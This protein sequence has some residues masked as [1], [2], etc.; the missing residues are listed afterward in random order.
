MLGLLMPH[1]AVKHSVKEFVHGRVYTNGMESFWSML[2]RGYVGVYH[3]MSPKH[4][5]RYMTEFQG[6]PNDSESDTIDQN[7]QLQGLRHR[8]T[9]AVAADHAD[10]RRQQ[11]GEV[12]HPACSALAHH[13]I[14][15][16]RNRSSFGPSSLRSITPDGWPGSFA[17][18][19]TS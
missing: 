2:K 3:K 13:A 1:E 12:E 17:P 8:P 9:T 5:H 19:R 15:T 4:L 16:E 7:R 6:R 18:S 14:E 11:C 10:L